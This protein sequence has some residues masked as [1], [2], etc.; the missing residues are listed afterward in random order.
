VSFEEMSSWTNEQFRDFGISK[1]LFETLTLLANGD[2]E[3]AKDAI[4]QG[5]A[6]SAE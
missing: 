6:E 1:D 3:K 4:L 2:F 5:S